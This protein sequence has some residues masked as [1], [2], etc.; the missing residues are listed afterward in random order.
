MQ[1][2]KFLHVNNFF[3]S[4]FLEDKLGKRKFLQHQLAKKKGCH[5]I[6]ARIKIT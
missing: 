2:L 1:N 6:Q 4:F 5:L 3:H